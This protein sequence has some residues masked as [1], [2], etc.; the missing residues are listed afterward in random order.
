MAVGLSGAGFVLLA[1]ALLRVPMVVVEQNAAPG[2]A[3]A[4]GSPLWPG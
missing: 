1:A 4:P 2:A 3:V